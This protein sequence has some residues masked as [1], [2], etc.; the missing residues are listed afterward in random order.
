MFVQILIQLSP[1]IY[2]LTFVVCISLALLNYALSTRKKIKKNLRHLQ[3]LHQIPC[4]RCMFYTGEHNL[5]CTVH[6]YKAFREEAID[7]KD[8]E[9]GK[10]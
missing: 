6:P 5:K 9:T 8:Y 2:K 3:R 7:C 4:S 1:L 10:S